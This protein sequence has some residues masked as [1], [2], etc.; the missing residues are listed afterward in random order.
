MEAVK[1]RAVQAGYQKLLVET[2]DSPTFENARN[3]YYA[4]GFVQTDRMENYLI[5]GSAM[6]VFTIQLSV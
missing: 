5:D 1:Q 6:I 3:F 4:W 2:Y